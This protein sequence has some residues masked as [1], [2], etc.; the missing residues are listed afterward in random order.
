MYRIKN[1]W[2]HKEAY[3]CFGCCPDN[4]SGVGMEFY[5]DGEEV[6]SY[7][8]PRAQF[9]GWIDTLHGGIQAVLLD[10]IC[11]WAVMY[12]LQTTGVTSKME[13]RYKRPLSTNDAYVVL[14]AAVTEVRRNIVTVEASIYDRSGALCTQ[15][16]C[17][18][19]TFG[20]EKAREMGFAGL[21]L[22]TDD[23]TEET[24]IGRLSCTCEE[25]N[26][27]TKAG[28]SDEKK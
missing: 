3:F 11:A 6:V 22:E 28:F 15:A 18:Y 25:G 2:L 4:H 26:C 10:E 8:K 7:W 1:P 13:A 21:E 17:T 5:A 16:V 14:R 9:Q 20:A 27:K 19:Y 23:V 24:A 12:R